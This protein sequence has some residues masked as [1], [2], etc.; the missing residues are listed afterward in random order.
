MNDYIFFM[1]N[2]YGSESVLFGQDW[3]AN[4]EWDINFQALLYKYKYINEYK[5]TK[6]KI[7]V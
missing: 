1:D 5:Y 6:D 7:R 3:G 4:K 2:L